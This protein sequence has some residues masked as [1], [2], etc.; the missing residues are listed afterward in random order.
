M[1][2]RLSK[3]NGEKLG[4]YYEEKGLGSIKQCV[5]GDQHRY[6][7]GVRLYPLKIFSGA[8]EQCRQ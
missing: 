4:E 7:E 5:P 2:W 1:S 3:R 8:S 6:R